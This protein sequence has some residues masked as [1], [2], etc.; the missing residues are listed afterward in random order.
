MSY[1]LYECKDELVPVENEINF[2]KNYIELE[3]LRYENQL[4]VELHISETYAGPK[5]APLLFISFIEN[6]FKHLGNK[7]N[8]KPYVIIKAIIE[9]EKI[10][11]SVVN[12]IAGEVNERIG[13]EGGV[14]IEN[15]QKRLE[16]LYPEKHTLMIEKTES[17]FIVTLSIVTHGA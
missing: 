13:K 8:Q 15:V 9:Q 17:E 6:A 16:L 1:I 3:K 14:G 2:L 4:A 7:G 12:S 5:V 11:L 10:S